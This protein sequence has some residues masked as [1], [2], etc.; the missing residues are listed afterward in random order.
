MGAGI[1]LRIYSEEGDTA[2]AV[3]SPIRAIGLSARLPDAAL[4]G[5]PT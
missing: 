3:L 4:P 1:R 2:A 5:L